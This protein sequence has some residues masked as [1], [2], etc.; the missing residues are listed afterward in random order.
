[1]MITATERL[2]LREAQLDD[3]EFILELINEPA[4]KAFIADYAIDDTTGARRYIEE[5]LLNSY[6]DNGYGLWLVELAQNSELVGMCGYVNRESLPGPDLGFAFLQRHWGKAYAFEAA[7]G[8]LDY[9]R[10]QALS[11]TIWA[12]TLPHNERSIRLLQ[13]LGF[14][15]QSGFIAEDKTKLSLYSVAL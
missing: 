11:D 14:R 8:A 7:T 1:M 6:R 2:R 5:R 10:E 12:I 13:R 3:A 4:W 15:Y 9:A